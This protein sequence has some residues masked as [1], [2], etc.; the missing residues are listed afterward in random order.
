MPR[1]TLMSTE[2]LAPL[3]ACARDVVSDILEP[4]I[5]H[6][7]RKSGYGL[8]YPFKHTL[9][10]SGHLDEKNLQIFS[11]FILNLYFPIILYNIGLFGAI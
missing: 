10:V 8:S 6:L 1:S 9:K 4:L 5:R 7:S 11:Y 2:L 3:L